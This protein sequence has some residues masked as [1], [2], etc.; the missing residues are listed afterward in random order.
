MTADDW[1]RRSVY[2]KWHV[3]SHHP[4]QPAPH[5]T[6][7]EVLR[8]LTNQ[9]LEGELPDKQLGRL[10]VTT[11]LSEGDRSGTEAVRL[12]DTTGRWCGLAS[13]LGGELLTWGLATSG[14]AS[15]LLGTGHC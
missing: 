1:K 3:M 12:L 2:G 6:H 15:G 13:G 9:P 8:N 10:L 7:L 11:N 4:A 14:L 5:N